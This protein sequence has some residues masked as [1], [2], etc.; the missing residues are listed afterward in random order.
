MNWI[1]LPIAFLGRALLS[2]IFI[3]S[4][5]GK[6]LDWNNTLQYFTQN[7]TAWQALN[8]LHPGLLNIIQFALDNAAPVLVLGVIFELLGGLLVFLGIWV[9]LGAVLLLI[10]LIPTTAVF[11]HFWQLQEPDKTLQMINFMKNLSIFGGLLYV[12]ALGKGGK[13]SK[14]KEKPA[15]K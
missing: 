7:L 3:A 10:F 11:H 1:Q 12:L 2:I 6:I 15:E 9:R 5:I 13:C 8:G 14:S 4:A